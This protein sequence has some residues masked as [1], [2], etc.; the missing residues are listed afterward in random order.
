MAT[1]KQ[2]D[3]WTKKNHGFTSKPCWIAHCKELAGLNPR[4]SHRRYDP[5]VRQVPCPP[6]KQPYIMSAFKHFEMI[7]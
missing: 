4:I 1:Y 2:I 7:S 6:E 3:L 5:D